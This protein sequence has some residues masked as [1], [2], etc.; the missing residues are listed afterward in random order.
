MRTSAVLS[1]VIPSVETMN[2]NGY[3]IKNHPEV[4]DVDGW[5]RTRIPASVREQGWAIVSWCGQE[6]WAYTVGLW[7][8]Y[9]RPE[10]VICGLGHDFAVAVL[11]HFAERVRN[12]V[13][14]PPD[15]DLGADPL[16]LRAVHDDWRSDFFPLIGDH[17]GDEV[18]PVWQACW[19]DRRDL[20]PGEAG[21]D[22]GQPLLWLSKAEHPASAWLK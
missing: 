1:D 3:V 14:F 8:S 9:R 6:S 10:V 5:L 2:N 19:P 16:I 12:G 22:G 11:Q 4:E 21:F 20:F 18:V 15:R 17:Y 7:E 13:E